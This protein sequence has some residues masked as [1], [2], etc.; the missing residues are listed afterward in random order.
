[1]DGHEHDTLSDDALAREIEAALD[2]DPSPEFQARVRARVAT[3]RIQSGWSGP[4]TWATV[5]LA[6]AAVAVLGVWLV[7]TTPDPAPDRAP[8][9]AEAPA[10]LADV[11]PPSVAPAEDLATG[12]RVVPV[13]SVPRLEAPMRTP[14]PEV[15]ISRQ[16]GADL[17]RLIDAIA[18]RRLPPA[19]LPDWDSPATP[20]DPIDEI[21]L[22]PI[23]LSPI[24][25][26]DNVEGVRQ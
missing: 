20:L 4:F 6:G 14:R 8:R 1:M 7:R 15:V 12:P 10:P 3:E 16:E 19:A 21:V 13:A 5:A 26:L 9:V 17:Q 25:R 23:T 11:A 22:E 24:V 2:V 18:S